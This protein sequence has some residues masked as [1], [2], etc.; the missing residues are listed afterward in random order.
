MSFGRRDTLFPTRSFHISFHVFPIL[1]G[2]LERHDAQ[3]KTVP[4]ESELTLK[5]VNVSLHFGRTHKKTKTKS[6]KQIC[7]CESK[8]QNQTEVSFSPLSKWY[9][10]NYGDCGCSWQIH[11]HLP[12]PDYKKIIIISFYMYKEVCLFTWLLFVLFVLLRI[13]INQISLNV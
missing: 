2:T 11:G 9:P 1:S 3:M 13:I 10:H 12:H 8:C 5:A 6:K 4:Q 7:L